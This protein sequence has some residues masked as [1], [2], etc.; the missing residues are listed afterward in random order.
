MTRLGIALQGV[1]GR[2]GF[3]TGVLYAFRK[4]KIKP[5][6][7][8]FTSGALHAVTCYLNKDIETAPQ[9]YEQFENY[10]QI[11][12]FMPRME[13]GVELLKAFLRAERTLEKNCIR[14]AFFWE[15]FSFS[16]PISTF[17]DFLEN[18]MSWWF[19]TI[20]SSKLLTLTTD[21]KFFEE[22]FELIEG[23]KIG[24]LTN[25]YDYEKN[26]TIIY[27]NSAAL[28]KLKNTRYT[29]GEHEHFEVKFIS[30]EGLRSCL[31][32]LQFGAPY[33]NEYDGAYQFNPYLPPVKI[34]DKIIIVSAT[35]LLKKRKPISTLFDIEEFK[36]NML[37]TN[38]I[39]SELANID[40]INHLIDKKI[41]TDKSLHKIDIKILEPSF[42]LGPLDYF[43]EN[44]DHFLDGMAQANKLIQN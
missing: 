5:E 19:E 10:F 13:G 34:C 12:P 20:F 25:S 18:P 3:S 31:H 6:M 7:I 33:A 22:A 11:N 27:M 8:S 28:K 44:K 39:Y 26:K 35:S 32:I 21:M 23:S 15:K 9:F 36:L 2:N 17:V 14:P 4:A 30:P 29:L 38:A 1:A 42:A 43:I 16:D 24:I 41:V 37:L 40:L